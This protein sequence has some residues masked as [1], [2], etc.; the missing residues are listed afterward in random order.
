[1]RPPRRIFLL[2]FARSA[3]AQAEF[4][5]IVAEGGVGTNLNKLDAQL[6]QQPL[7]ADGSRLCDALCLRA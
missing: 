7:L 6:A 2:V 1:M 4:D 5:Q 3:P